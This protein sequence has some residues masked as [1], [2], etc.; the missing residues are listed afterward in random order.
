MRSTLDPVL[1]LN[2]ET[3][4]FGNIFS[5]FKQIFEEKY[6]VERG[7]VMTRNWGLDVFL[8]RQVF[9]RKNDIL[10]EDRHRKTSYFF[11]ANT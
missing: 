7:C 8:C 2:V 1:R 9:A 4:F 3:V 11:P 6:C 5:D 10:P